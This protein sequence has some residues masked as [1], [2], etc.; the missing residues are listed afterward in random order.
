MNE[1]ILSFLAS[2]RRQ[3]P[4]PFEIVNAYKHMKPQL[5]AD[6][7]EC[8]QQFN[9]AEGWV[10][11]S[12]LRLYPLEQLKWINEIYHIREFLPDILL[13]GSTGCGEAYAFDL[14]SDPAKI[15][16]VPFIPLDRDYSDFTCENFTE[17]ITNLAS[18][19][20]DEST[21][22]EI[23]EASFQKEVHEKHPIVLG[24]DP[25]DPNNKVLL[26]TNIHAEATYFFNKVFKRIKEQSVTGRS[27]G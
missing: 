6:Y 7:L 27:G 23:N 2:L 24:G 14:R 3:D 15:I 17:F 20:L 13:F 22:Y 16:K 5:P 11:C 26:P 9:G 1:N 25:T 19:N 12:Y 21:C 4:P 8:I 18:D 10:R